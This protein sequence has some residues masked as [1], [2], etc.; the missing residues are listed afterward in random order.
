M[1]AKDS[2]Q[3]SLLAPFKR[4]GFNRTYY[5]LDNYKKKIVEDRKRI[6]P[7]KELYAS[8]LKNSVYL[9]SDSVAKLGMQIFRAF[10]K[11]DQYI[12]EAGRLLNVLVNENMVGKDSL[13]QH[14]KYYDAALKENVCWLTTGSSQLQAVIKGYKRML[15]RQKYMKEVIRQ[16]NRIEAARYRAINAQTTW[17]KKKYGSIPPNNLRVCSRQKSTVVKY[18]KAYL[19]KLKDARR[20]EREEARKKKK[21]Y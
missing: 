11:R 17:R 13:K 14:I 9:L 6:P 2:V 18:K 21:K 20:K 15:N 8:D 1:Y 4:G 12:L 16:E 3:D 10:D 19:K 7:M 5:L